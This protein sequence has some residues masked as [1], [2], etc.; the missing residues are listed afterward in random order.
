[1]LQK[2]WLVFQEYHIILWIL[3]LA[4]FCFV[5]CG[6]LESAFELAENVAFILSYG[7]EHW[8]VREIA[9]G[10][11]CFFWKEL[12]EGN[13]GQQGKNLKIATRGRL[14]WK[15]KHIYFTIYCLMHNLLV[16]FYSII[17]KLSFSCSHSCSSPPWTL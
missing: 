6:V 17:K 5:L 1:M 16:P 9:S 4:F 11:F 14:L 13:W 8:S 3:L 7:F 2:E 12:C 15:R 10:C